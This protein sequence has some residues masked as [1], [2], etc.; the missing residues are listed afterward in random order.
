MAFEAL[1]A[2]EMKAIGVKNSDKIDSLIPP[3]QIE[4]TKRY[5]REYQPIVGITPGPDHTSDG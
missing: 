2:D 4:M 3:E 1:R 5:L